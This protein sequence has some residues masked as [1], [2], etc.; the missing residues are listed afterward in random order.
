MRSFIIFRL[1][2]SRLGAMLCVP[3]AFAVWRQ[4]LS[5][6]FTCEVQE[7]PTPGD[8]GPIQRVDVEVGDGVIESFSVPNR[9]TARRPTDG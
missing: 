6:R 3:G 4:Q 5:Y 2:W 7:V 8:G 1:A 9:H